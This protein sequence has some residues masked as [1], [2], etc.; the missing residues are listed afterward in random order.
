MRAFRDLV[1]PTGADQW[2]GALQNQ[3]RSKTNEGIFMFCAQKLFGVFGSLTVAI[4]PRLMSCRIG[5]LPMR[6]L[7]PLFPLLLPELPKLR[8][9]RPVN[10]P[11]SRHRFTGRSLSIA[12]QFFPSEEN[13]QRV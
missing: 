8:P 3:A 6:A 1:G 13:Q 9:V 12:T 5:K 2:R 7:N 10:L 4:V 11:T